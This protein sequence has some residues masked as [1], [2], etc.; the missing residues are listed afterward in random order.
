MVMKFVTAF[1][2]LMAA[3]LPKAFSQHPDDKSTAKRLIEKSMEAMGKGWQSVKSISFDGY[4]Y[5][6]LIDQ[7]ERQE[8]P[9]IPV[10]IQRS[11]L[12]DLPNGAF[13]VN[14]ATQSYNFKDTSTLLFNGEAIAV[15]SGQGFAPARNG[16]E[17]RDE[18]NLSPELIL[19]KALAS[20]DLKYIKDT[21]FQKA[22]HSIIFFKS[23]GYPVRFFLNKETDLLSAVEITKPFNDDFSNIWGDVKK[24]IIYSFWM[25]LGN[26]VHYPLQWD[27]YLNDWYKESFLISSWK[28]NPVIDAASL[29]ITAKVKEDGKQLAGNENEA[30]KKK[31]EEGGKE[32]A[33]G[34]WFLAGICNSTIINQPDGIVVI[35]SPLSSRYGELIIAKVNKLF[36]GKKIK[37][38]VS[39]SNAWLHIG[40]VRAFA[41]IPGIKIYHPARNR[42]IL[43]KLLNAPFT[44]EPDILAKTLRPTYTLTGVTDTLAIGSGDTRLVMYAYQTETG[45][46]QMMVYFPQYKLVYTSDLYQ[47][48]NTKDKYWNPHIVWEVYHSIMTRKINVQ[49]FYSTHSRGLIP[50]KDLEK[51]VEAGMQ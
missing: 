22:K 12:K 10:Q 34:V 16:Q 38:L 51:D 23:N 21:V 1:F 29:Q 49:Q 48:S 50:F 45:D 46:R 32:I 24:T 43:E 2:L 30:F 6:G 15:K 28:I 5:Q 27:T 47:G 26:G 4:G 19:S 20:P 44:T 18:L 8:G 13:L 9:Y 37:A 41:A 25:L 11:I 36:P 14:Q 3:V 31:I 33:P 35:E 40:G 17:L 42:Q 7:S 39:T